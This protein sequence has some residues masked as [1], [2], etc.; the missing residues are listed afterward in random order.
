MSVKQNSSGN[1]RKSA[2]SLSI[3]DAAGMTPVGRQAI[4]AWLRQAAA[5]LLKDGKKYDQGFKASYLYE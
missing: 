2:A 1:S 4:A 5:N 3:P